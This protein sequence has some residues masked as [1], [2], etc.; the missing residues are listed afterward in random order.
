MGPELDDD[1]SVRRIER[2][3]ALAAAGG[4]EAVVVLTK[5]DL[6]ADLDRMRAD[7][8]RVAGDRPIVVASPLH[9]HGVARVAEHVP[10]GRTAVLLGSSGVGKSTLLNAL[11]DASRARTQPVADDGRGRHTTTHR[12]LFSIPGG[13]LVAD[14]PG[15]REV[16]VIG[17]DEAL[18]EAFSDVADLGARCRFGDC[19]HETEPG[20]A[21]QDALASGELSTERFASYVALRREA[22]AHARRADEHARRRHDK[23]HP[24]VELRLQRRRGR[25]ED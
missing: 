20:C 5:A 18:D 2:Y 25:R 13:G 19:E 17:T 23:A 9:G 22:A 11:L 24:A 12:E 15:I 1:F 10:P 16:G 8:E 14:G 21:V 6:C 7:A 3:L 4:V